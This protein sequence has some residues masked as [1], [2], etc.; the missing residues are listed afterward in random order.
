MKSNSLIYGDG[1]L[2]VAAAEGFCC[3][4]AGKNRQGSGVI[5]IE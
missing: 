2:P 3:D 1:V 4:G 5:T